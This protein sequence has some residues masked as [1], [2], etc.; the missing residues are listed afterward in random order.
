MKKLIEI[1]AQPTQGFPSSS[2]KQFDPLKVFCRI[3]LTGK[4]RK[5]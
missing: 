2:D 5:N 3:G 4:E 1:E